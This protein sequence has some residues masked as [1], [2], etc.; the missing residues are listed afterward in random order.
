MSQ[1]ATGGGSGAF[2]LQDGTVISAS[3]NIACQ[4]SKSQQLTMSIHSANGR[5]IFTQNQLVASFQQVE[6]IRF[7]EITG[8]SKVTLVHKVISHKSTYQSDDYDDDDNEDGSIQV[9]SL[10]NMPLDVDLDAQISAL[11]ELRQQARTLRQLIRQKETDI[12]EHLVYTDSTEGDTPT[13]P[14][15]DCNDLG[16]VFRGLAWKIKHAHG[17][18][19][20]SS[21]QWSRVLGCREDLDDYTRDSPSE[22]SRT[23]HHTH[24]NDNDQHEHK[25]KHRHVSDRIV[26]YSV[27]LLTIHNRA[28]SHPL[29]S[30]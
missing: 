29:D 15:K 11:E 20:S 27:L 4:K 23:H 16:C 19:C 25:H 5:S 2:T 18:V 8:A 14:L 26:F 10:R 3:W 13:P 28:A 1:N 12:M 22:H 17:D 7:L 30:S 6:P 21:P 24:I 9:E